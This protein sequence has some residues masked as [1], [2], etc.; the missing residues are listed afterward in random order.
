MTRIDAGRKAEAF[1]A[2]S[3]R[4][5]VANWGGAGRWDEGEDGERPWLPEDFLSEYMK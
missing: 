5:K 2:D 3:P 1:P 4:P